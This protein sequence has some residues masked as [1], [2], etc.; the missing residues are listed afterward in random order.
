MKKKR[1]VFLVILVVLLT[2]VG[3]FEAVLFAT[4]K[5]QLIDRTVEIIFYDSKSEP[6]PSNSILQVGSQETPIM[7]TPTRSID[8]FPTI[9]IIIIEISPNPTV[10]ALP[11]YQPT[12][13]PVQSTPISQT[14]YITKTGSKYH[15][16]G[17]QYLRNSK[18]PI[19]LSTAKA[20]GYTPCKICRHGR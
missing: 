2:L 8:P 20:Q 1:S 5:W 4:Y 3:I 14:V 13:A 15:S 9:P 10:V 7:T 18:I 19:S 12:A 17:C 6:T 16:A 11:S